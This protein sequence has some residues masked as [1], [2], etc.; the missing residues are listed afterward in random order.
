MS[1]DGQIRMSQGFDVL[2][3][4]SGEAFPIPCEEWALLKARLNQVAQNP[5]GFHTLG[6]L[7]VGAALSPL[8]TIL[9]GG[10][11]NQ[12][13]NLVIAWASVSVCVLCGGLCIY[14]AAREKKMSGEQVGNIVS[15]MELIERRYQRSGPPD[16]TNTFAI[17]SAKYGSDSAMVDVTEELVALIDK[18]RVQV[19]VGNALAGDPCPGTAKELVVEYVHEGVEHRAQVKEHDWLSIP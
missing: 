3:P 1:A 14:F 10:I 6:S 9:A 15:Q 11:P 16:G 5:W 17:R 8:V 13:S 4:K 19:K 18:G 12:G 2:P 7:L